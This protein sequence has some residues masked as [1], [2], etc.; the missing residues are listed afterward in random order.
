[1][2]DNIVFA[3]DRV[4]DITLNQLKHKVNDACEKYEKTTT[5]NEPF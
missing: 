1:M 5:K 4:Q 3:K 2:S